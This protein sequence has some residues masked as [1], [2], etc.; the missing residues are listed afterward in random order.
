MFL[1][2]DSQIIDNRYLVFINDILSSGYIPEL[3]AKDEVE[4]IQGKVRN[5]AK[6]LGYA[7]EPGPLFEFFL[8]KVRNN[9]H[10][11]LCFS[12]VGE[13]FRYRARQFPG[14]I[15]DTSIDWF[16]AWPEDALVGVAA[17]F[18][19][20]VEFPSDEIRAQVGQHMANVHLSIDKA[21]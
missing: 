14:I 9:L 20:E 12:P 18:L 13:A 16:T 19:G 4:E 11:D 6:S 17:R 5:E 21:N 1:L 10:I 8:N 3:F 2:T 15:N 7:D